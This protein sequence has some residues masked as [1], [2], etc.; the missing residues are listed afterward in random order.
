MQRRFHRDTGIVFGFP[1]QNM[2]KVLGF[3]P[4]LV[5]YKKEFFCFLTGFVKFEKMLYE[6]ACLS[7]SYSDWERIFVF[8]F[9]VP[10]LGW[11]SDLKK[12]LIKYLNLHIILDKQKLYVYVGVVCYVDRF[13]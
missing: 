10:N 7:H 8:L 4:E 9:A 2:P 6:I 12:K 3:S 1:K 11:N 13:F 5:T